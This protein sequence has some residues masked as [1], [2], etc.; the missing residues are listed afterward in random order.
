MDYKFKL[1][2][3]KAQL[4]RNQIL[5]NGAKNIVAI[6]DENS[7]QY[8]RWHTGHLLQA[9]NYEIILKE[10]LS[11]SN[12]GVIFKPKKPISFRKRIGDVSKLLLE[13]ENSGR[14]YVYDS[15]TDD[16]NTP[17]PV[18]AGMSADICIHSHLCAGTAAIEC[19]L[20]KLP[21]IL[22]DREGDPKNLLYTLSD[23]NIIF[24]NW[25]D[26]IYA[27]NQH[28]NSKNKNNNF[29]KWP[30]YFLNSL[31]NFR[32]GKAAFRMGEYLNTMI[33][34]IKQNKS[35]DEAMN[36]AAE[37][38]TKKYGKDKVSTFN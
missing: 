9:E 17:S 8:P 4:I 19:A 26:A 16:F 12:L 34:Y 18:L 1:L 3:E 13:A 2:K 37:I 21:T 14:C 10:L 30:E 20:A 35:R 31:D 7:N 29:G 33:N 24:N 28:F 11:N 25:N 22:I 6:F 23:Q 36:I 32:D 38:Y 15:Y 27:V 5:N